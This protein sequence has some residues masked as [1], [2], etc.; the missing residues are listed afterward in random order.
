ML[1]YIYQP[2]MRIHF[3]EFRTFWIRI[4][5]EN[6]PVGPKRTARMKYSIWA[7]AEVQQKKEIH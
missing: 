7:L 6:R 4:P 1:Y 2:K 5:A 3:Q